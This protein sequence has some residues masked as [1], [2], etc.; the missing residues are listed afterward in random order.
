MRSAIVCHLWRLDFLF[1]V[2]SPYVNLCP[3]VFP[4]AWTLKY[5][6]SSCKIIQKCLQIKMYRITSKEI[7]QHFYSNTWKKL[8][9]WQAF[10]M[11]ELCRISTVS[12]MAVNKC[13]SRNAQ[14]TS[15]PVIKNNFLKS[16]FIN[17]WNRSAIS[18]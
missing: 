17:F 7:S 6:I 15:P 12:W 4:S 16:G 5:I 14:C 18:F 2:K 9:S 13:D 8:T 1:A 3:G 11:E 10:T